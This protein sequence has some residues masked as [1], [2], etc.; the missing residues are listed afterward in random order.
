MVSKPHPKPEPEPKPVHSPIPVNEPLLNGSERKYL[1]ECL[2]TRWISSEGPFVR[3]FEEKFASRVGRKH[4]IAVCNGTAALEVAVAALEFKPGDKVILPSFTIISCAAAIVRGGCVPVVVDSDPKT[5]NM[6]AEKLKAKV[7]VEVEK[8]K[9][10]K[11]KAIMVVHIYGLPTDMDPVLEIAEKYGLKVIED[12][13]QS[14][15]STRTSTSPLARAGWW[16]RTTTRSR[17]GAGRFATFASSR[18][19]G[20]CTTSWG[21]I[22]G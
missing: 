10:R 4:G 14:S 20:L 8:K 9:N 19:A 15:A 5:W 22:T 11:L 17:R 1:L 12:A 6:D 3:Q 13:A 7:K 18:S 16:S 2:D 21:S